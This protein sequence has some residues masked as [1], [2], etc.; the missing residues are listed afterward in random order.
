[1]H[2]VERNSFIYL[3]G[4]DEPHILYYSLEDS[5]IAVFWNKKC[6]HLERREI[7]GGNLCSLE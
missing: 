4:R 1:M 6:Q 5:K 2:T 7:I 3:R